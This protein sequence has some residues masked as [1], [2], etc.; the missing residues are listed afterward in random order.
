MPEGALQSYQAVATAHGSSPYCL[1]QTASVNFSRMLAQACHFGSGP[2]S[3]SLSIHILM[4]GSKQA[5]GLHTSTS[6][7][8]VSPAHPLPFLAHSNSSFQTQLS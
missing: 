4:K 5:L 6:P 2:F 8:A 1:S 3:V 7:R